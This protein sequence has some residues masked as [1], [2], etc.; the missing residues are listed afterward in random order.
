MMGG[1][2]EGVV[3]LVPTP[4]SEKG[5]GMRLGGGCSSQSESLDILQ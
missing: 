4:L 5:V 3:S 1:F 2:A